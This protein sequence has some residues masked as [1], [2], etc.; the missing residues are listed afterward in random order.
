MSILHVGHTHR[1]IADSVVDH[2]VHRH[3]HRVLGQHLLRH[4]IKHLSSQVNSSQF[5]NARQDEVKSWS[6]GATV[7]DT[8]NTKYY[9]SLVLLNNL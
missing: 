2:R 7:L 3:R 1:G 5:V 6:L 9:R 8:S 4:H